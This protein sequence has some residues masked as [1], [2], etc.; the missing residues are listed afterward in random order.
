MKPRHLSNP[1]R[2]D[3]L[4]VAA[5]TAATAA[6]GLQNLHAQEVTKILVGFAAGGAIDSTARI[7]ATAAKELGSTIVDNRP[8]A[9][10][11]IAAGALAQARADGNTVM[12]APLNVYCIAQ[13]IY[14]KLP[15]DAAHD[16][17]PVGIVARFPSALAVHPNVP[18]QNM[19]DF[20]SWLKANRDRAICGMGA[21]GS[22]VHLMA[23]AFSRAIGVEFTF[24]PYKGGAL[25]VQDLMAG[26]IPF[27]FDPIV[28]LAE[29]HK[30]G[31]LRALAF[32][33]AERSAVLP[34]VPT[35]QELGFKGVTGDTWIGAS[36]RAGTP[37]AKV[38][39]LADG[40]ASAAGQADVKA[41]LAALGLTAVA[42]TPAGMRKTIEADTERYT[43]LVKMMGLKVD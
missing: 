14:R 35:L 20:V 21:I 38:Q 41:R 30:A 40:L 12:F 3:V 11:N 29:P 23:Y 24:A 19:Q 17:T 36:V 15:F 10:G 18:A 4:K 13:A 8:G 9:G 39:A 1:N 37:A 43:G 2:R 26:H 16:F 5:A 22:E 32:T 6:M 31:K 42:A 27:A 28:N 7:Y 25:M 34:E 33:S